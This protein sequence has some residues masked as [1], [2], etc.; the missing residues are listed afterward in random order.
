MSAVLRGFMAANCNSSYLAWTQVDGP[1]SVTCGP[2]GGYHRTVGWDWEVLEDKFGRNP[3]RSDW[4]LAERPPSDYAA[5]HVVSGYV[6]QPN[7]SA[8]PNREVAKVIGK[9][10]SAVSFSKAFVD[11]SIFRNSTLER[12][13]FNG[14]RI[15]ATEFCNCELKSAEFIGAIFL[16]FS[17]AHDK[18]HLTPWLWTNIEASQSTFKNS[19]MSS[20]GRCRDSTFTECCFDGSAAHAQFRTTRFKNCTFACSDLSGNFN[21]VVFESCSFS[22]SRLRG[23]FTNTRFK[24][25]SFSESDFSGVFTACEFIGCRIVR[26]RV[27]GTFS[28]LDMAHVD[29][30]SCVFDGPSFQKVNLAGGQFPNTKWIRPSFGDVN[31]NGCNF[32][33]SLII[34]PTFE[35]VNLSDANLREVV[36]ESGTLANVN[37]DRARLE[38]SRLIN[39]KFLNSS[40]RQA[41]LTEANLSGSWFLVVDGT[42][43][44]LK[45]AL[46]YGTNFQRVTLYDAIIDNADFTG[47]TKYRVLVDHKA[48]RSAKSW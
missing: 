4:G 41:D 35:D 9:K 28:N 1:S 10:L 11:N 19:A 30:S 16:D 34:N 33:G 42:G 45:D 15:L 32:L 20:D 43:A 2:G 14:T 27:M 26:G 44:V 40:M 7:D 36:I 38:N 6:A 23:S 24:N 37:L 18:G 29:L 21:D 39:A 48:A 47:S 46:A 13:K 17:P 31:L 25:C 3:Y 12:F 8:H 5:E 22:E